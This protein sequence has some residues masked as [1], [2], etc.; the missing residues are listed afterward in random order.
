VSHDLDLSRR[1]L[2]ERF[3]VT[4]WGFAYPFSAASQSTNDPRI[5]QELD[6]LVAARF[7]LAFTNTNDPRAVVAPWTPKGPLPRMRVDATTT[8][9]DL[10]TRL[11]D[12]TEDSA[13]VLGASAAAVNEGD[14]P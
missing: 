4:A 1:N 9:V 3:G 14:A 6:S 11:R 8:A 5:S 13:V 2:L 10:L 12:A 7:P